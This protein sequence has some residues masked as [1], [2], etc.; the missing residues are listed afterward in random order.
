MKVKLLTFLIASFIFV[1]NAQ[2]VLHYNNKAIDDTH[3]VT[4]KGFLYEVS[5]SALSTQAPRWKLLF[6]KALVWLEYVRSD[7]EVYH[8]E[9]LTNTIEE[10]KIIADTIEVILKVFNGD[11]NIDPEYAVVHWSNI[12]QRVITNYSQQTILNRDTGQSELKTEWKFELRPV[13]N[14]NPTRDLLYRAW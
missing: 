4:I 14:Q 13:P 11:F 9:N 12:G 3:V 8:L 1:S 10:A 6:A 5:H 2:A 7:S